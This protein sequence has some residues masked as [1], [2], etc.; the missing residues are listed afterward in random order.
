MLPAGGDVSGLFGCCCC[1][2][3][4]SEGILKST[5][6]GSGGRIGTAGTA[7]TAF[8]EGRSTGFGGGGGSGRDGGAP[9]RSIGTS[10]N[11]TTPAPAAATAPAAIAQAGSFMGWKIQ[12]RCFDT[13][14]M[15]VALTGSAKESL[16]PPD[17]GGPAAQGIGT[18][19]AS[20]RG[21]G[22][23]WGWGR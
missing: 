2:G 19:A 11:P 21:R 22:Q 3:A 10:D 16:P 4:P 18:T 12:D 7:D 1:D 17:G 15:A 9:I 5:A 8:G 23:A 13:A 6:S 20:G 14:P